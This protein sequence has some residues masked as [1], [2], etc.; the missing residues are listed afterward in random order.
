MPWIKSLLSTRE[1]G[2]TTEQLAL[3]HL[4]S[5]GLKLIEQNKHFKCGELDL[6]CK[7]G[8]CY[9]FVEVK[10]RKSNQYGGAATAVSASKQQK[11]KNSASLYLQQLGLNEYNTPCRFDVVALEGDLAQPQITWLKNAF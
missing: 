9:V 8:D 6:V 10:Y 4:Q 11:V 1:K 5:S 7:D 2:Q 3:T